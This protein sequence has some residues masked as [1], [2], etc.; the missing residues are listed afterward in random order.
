MFRVHRYNKTNYLDHFAFI[1]VLL[2]SH[3]GQRWEGQDYIHP[4]PRKFLLEKNI[5]NI[6]NWAQTPM[7]RGFV[8]VMFY[9]DVVMF[10]GEN[11]PKKVNFCS[12]LLQHLP[13][14][15]GRSPPWSACLR[16][17]KRWRWETSHLTKKRER[18]S[19]SHEGNASFPR[20]ER[21]I[22]TKGTNHSQR[23]NICFPFLGTIRSFW[24]SPFPP[25]E[26]KQGQTRIKA[27]TVMRHLVASSQNADFRIE[28][29][30]KASLFSRFLPHFRQKTSQ[31]H[32]KTSPRQTLSP[33]AFAP[34]WWC[35]WCF[36][37][38][39]FTWWEVLRGTG[40]NLSLLLIIGT[41]CDQ[42]HRFQQI[43]IFLPC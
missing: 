42:E 6:T 7:V 10:S 21:I 40:T 20:R 26:S 30:Q 17:T 18:M 31:H 35:L 36:F 32:H 15:L 2:R 25:K 43:L 3:E 34:N 37:E 12:T 22:P 14:R 5:T 9:G 28:N 19:H 33:S 23:G 24:W 13:L 16:C 11:R 4:L 1:L 29:H 39:K 41:I 38:Q 8:V 27:V